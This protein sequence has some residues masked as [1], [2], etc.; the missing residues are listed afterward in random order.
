MGATLRQLISE[1]SMGNT[2]LEGFDISKE[3]FIEL[4]SKYFNDKNSSTLREETMCYISGIESNPNKLGYD[5]KTTK[6][7]NKPKNFDTTN[8]K[9]KK[10]N[11]GGNYSDM[12]HKRDE[13]F[14]LDNPRIHIGGFVDGKLVYQ[15][16]IPYNS[17]GEHF[18]KQLNKRLPDGDI[19]NNYLRSMTFS[20]KTIQECKDVELE[21]LTEDIEKYRGFITKTLYTYLNKLKKNGIKK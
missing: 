19:K 2:N 10:L 4:L 13:K 9:A 20:L 7:E 17:L 3:N 8:P 18:K 12:T 11:G 21:F 6:D 5:G 15:F 16:K 14:K 1:Y